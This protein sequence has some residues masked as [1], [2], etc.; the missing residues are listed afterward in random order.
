M[1]FKKK[2]AA[3]AAAATAAAGGSG[4]GSTTALIGDLTPIARKRIMSDIREFKLGNHET[5]GIHISES[6]QLNVLHA[7]IIGPTET[8]YQDGFFFFHIVF[9]QDYPFNPP[10]VTFMTR[11]PTQNTRFH[12]NLYVEGKVCLSM[13]NTWQGPTWS[14]T[15]TLT[16]VLLTIQSIMDA[17]PLRN[18]PSYEDCKATDTRLIE[19]T[20]AIEYHNIKVAMHYLSEIDRYNALASFAQTIRTYFVQHY[21]AYVKAIR[22]HSA[23]WGAMKAYK[24]N[25]YGFKTTTDW[26]R[27][28][29]QAADLWKRFS[30]TTTSS[31]SASSSSSSAART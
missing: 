22:A 25:T 11:D 9:P 10:K 15:L 23:K 30:T 6:D 13:L 26:P 27:L 4:N 18:E 12:P 20:R 24:E 2:A 1:M 5:R 7:L 14:S 19:Y 21:D 17:H 16:A 28:E 29:K 3:T 31:S 8:P